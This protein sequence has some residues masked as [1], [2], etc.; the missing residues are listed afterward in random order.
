MSSMSLTCWQLNKVLLLSYL[1]SMTK[2][3]FLIYKYSNKLSKESFILNIQISSDQKYVLL[4]FEYG[5]IFLFHYKELFTI[6]PVKSDTD[7]LSNIFNLPVRHHLRFHR[8]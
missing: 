3:D 6:D 7:P 5:D 8:D 4:G 2:D 1:G